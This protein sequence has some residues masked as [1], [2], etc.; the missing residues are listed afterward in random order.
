L[1]TNGKLYVSAQ[2]EGSKF[3]DKIGSGDCFM[4]GLI[5]GN[6]RSLSPQK[7][8]DFAAAAAYSKLFIKGD[9][10]TASVRDIESGLLSRS[11][12]E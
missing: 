10:T 12:K 8:I 3:V 4:A 9:A 5:Y 2:F 11:G 1:Y 6:Q 7:T